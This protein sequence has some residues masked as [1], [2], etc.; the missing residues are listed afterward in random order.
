MIMFEDTIYRFRYDERYKMS[1]ETGK[2]IG[3]AISNVELIVRALK[4][5]FLTEQ[6]IYR[7][8]CEDELD[9]E[10]KLDEIKLFIHTFPELNEKSLAKRILL[11]TEFSYF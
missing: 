4:H 5:N 1:Y 2:R 9:F 8:F 6:E 11:E 7:Y 10:K 3:H